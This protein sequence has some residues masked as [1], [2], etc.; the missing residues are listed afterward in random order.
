[1]FLYKRDKK[2]THCPFTRVLVERIP[3]LDFTQ[4][5]D[6]PRPVSIHLDQSRQI[7]AAIPTFRGHFGSP[8]LPAHVWLDKDSLVLLIGNQSSKRLYP[9]LL[10]Q[11]IYGGGWIKNNNNNNSNRFAFT[12]VPLFNA[13][14]VLEG[15][16]LLCPPTSIPL[17][18]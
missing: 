11:G 7:G 14:Q 13:Y 1:M 3:R 5:L 9:F 12:S 10:E 2:V 4:F 17:K 18:R 16:Q 6:S 15:Y 8:T